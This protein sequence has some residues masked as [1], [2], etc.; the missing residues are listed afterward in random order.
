MYEIVRKCNP[1][2]DGL[3]DV[4]IEK[5]R[6]MRVKWI[7][8]WIDKI[9]L[10]PFS[11]NFVIGPRQVGKTTGVK[12]L[13]YRL[14]ED[15]VDPYRIFYF[16]CDF[17]SDFN[18]L[19][20][21]IDFYFS[22]RSS[23]GFDGDVCYLFFDEINSVNDWWRVI[24]GYIDLGAF[25]RDVIVL[26]GSSSLRLRGE[27][28]LFPGRRGFGRD[29]YVY[30]LSFREFA[31]LF[32]FKFD[33]SGD[34]DRD[35]IGLSLYRDD[36][37]RIFDEYVRFGG[38]PLSI[39]RDPRA[40]EYFLLGFQGELLRIG[41]RIELVRSIV[42]SIFRKA[43]SPISYST[44]G[45]DV[46]VSY[47]TVQDYIDVLRCLFIL[48][49]AYFKVDGRIVWRKERKFFV[50]DPFI[51]RCL[52]FWVGESFLESAFYEWIVQ[53]HLFRRFGSV[54][55]FRDRFEIDCIADGFRVEV[56]AGKPFRRYPKN[57]LVIG[58]DDIPVFLYALGV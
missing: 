19:R 22:F 48:G 51:A 15:G 40:E 9:S 5:W 14:L 50:L 52:S 44:I 53:S 35:F 25:S 42:S 23:H 4:D 55:Y 37:I 34:F 45:R 36:L 29:V 39:N 1:W 13:I 12:L 18:Y 8:S 2:W 28:E 43:P 10:K 30:P 11:L 54:Y 24:K 56:K 20:R 38:F 21:I 27:V 47:K 17:I 41:R 58:R 33:L 26:T 6:G 46:G 3:V 32:G 57:V 16:N 31:E 49:I 7:P